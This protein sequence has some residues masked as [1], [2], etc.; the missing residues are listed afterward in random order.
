MELARLVRI[1]RDGSNVSGGTGYLIARHL[2]L[3]ARHVVAGALRI[4]VH[5][6]GADGKPATAEPS[7][8][9]YLGEG[10]LDI[11][12]LR[13]ATGLDLPTVPLVPERS[14]GD[15][16]WRSRG[17]ARA[18]KKVENG[19]AGEADRMSALAG[20]AYEFSQR[21]RRI[22]LGVDDP[23]TEGD[24][25]KGAS[26]APVFVSDR[27]V[28]RLV[29]VIAQRDEPFEGNR[30]LAVPLAAAWDDPRFRVA[31]GYDKSEDER[32][33]CRREELIS[34]LESSLNLHEDAA[35]AIAAEHPPWR[36]A[37]EQK[38]DGGFRSLATALCETPSWR[39]VIEALD[40][41]HLQLVEREEL[42]GSQRPLLGSGSE[43]IVRIVERVLPEVY[44]STT[45]ERA[46]AGEGSFI[47]LPVETA[48]LAEIAMAAIDGRCLALDEVREKKTFPKS[49]VQ[50]DPKH[51]RVPK[52]FD[53]KREA[54]FSEWLVVIARWIGLDPADIDTL[55]LPHR[56]DELARRIDSEI[57]A[58]VRR[59]APR[60]YFVY[61]SEFAD[62]NQAFLREFGNALRSLR[63]VELTGKGLTEERDA[64]EPLRAIL[65]RSYERRNKKGRR[66]L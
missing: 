35:R 29:G 41:A 33:R 40:R 18:A 25:W 10:D 65:F 52:G 44:Y 15:R 36:E 34:T 46:P 1:T 6:D 31:I 38:D 8:P 19:E 55:R 57:E 48:T 61:P 28:E 9:P 5:Y 50:I 66:R 14:R 4:E 43:A 22:Q 3:T 54:A 59:R 62:R 37:L 39:Q 56:L 45:R 30:L 58:D 7:E 27:S 11:A 17:W 49:P 12:V 51:S 20:K 42:D 53:F 64:C 32:R 23:P 21:A 16:P 26:G 60:R 2:V 13:I 63:F 47:E 24:W